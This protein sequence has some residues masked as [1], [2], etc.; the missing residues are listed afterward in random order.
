MANLRDR[1]IDAKI[2]GSRE[3]N[4]YRFNSNEAAADEAIKV[5]VKWLRELAD[6]QRA[7]AGV[8]NSQS[9]RDR[10]EQ[11]ARRYDTMIERVL[12]T[13]DPTRGPEVIREVLQ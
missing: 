9:H 13:H 6:V 2:A 7:N 1:L 10:C 11:A 12:D 4:G 8:I 5:L 3:G